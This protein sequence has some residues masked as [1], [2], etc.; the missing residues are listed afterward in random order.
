MNYSL[1]KTVTDATSS[2][3][4]N[5]IEHDVSLD[6]CSSARSSINVDAV[7]YQARLS[8]TSNRIC[9]VENEVDINWSLTT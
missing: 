1:S 7:I 5:N 9:V 2:I 3:K 6:Q 8:N 4:L